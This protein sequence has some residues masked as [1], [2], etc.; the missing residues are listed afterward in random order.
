M[1]FRSLTNEAYK[2]IAGMLYLAPSISA[3]GNRNP[4]SYFRLVPHQEAPT[5]ICWGDMNRSAL[6][7]VPLGWNVKRNMSDDANGFEQSPMK[8][9]SSKQ[10]VEFRCPDGSADIYLLLAS[11]TVAVR[12]GFE[13]ENGVEYAKD[14]YISVNIFDDEHKGVAA[15]MSQLPASCVESADRLEQQREIYEKYGVFSKGLIDG[16]I[17]LLNSFNDSNLRQ[18]LKDPDAML[19]Y[20]KK[21]INCG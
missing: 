21:F 9:Y 20:V 6:V 12:H 1:L 19:E 10:T 7:R 8:D 17:A 18:E 3:F 2:A 13:I 5:N 16:T 11:L 14:R 15:K 4:T